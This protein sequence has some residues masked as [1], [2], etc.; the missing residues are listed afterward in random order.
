MV[1]QTQYI[2]R[3]SP[4]RG[5]VGTE[6]GSKSVMWGVGGGGGIIERQLRHN[7]VYIY[8]L[9]LLFN[10]VHTAIR[11][12][13]SH[14]H[15][16]NVCLW[17]V[18]CCLPRSTGRWIISLTPTTSSKLHLPQLVLKLFQLTDAVC[19]CVC[20]CVCVWYVALSV[21][22]LVVSFACSHCYSHFL[23]VVSQCGWCS[24]NL[25]SIQCAKQKLCFHVRG[26]HF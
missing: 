3:Q 19:V 26:L 24:L 16:H 8:F 11:I 7:N 15:E 17:T 18:F 25:N 14:M 6:R 21:W 5:L 23:L 10:L 12:A 9:K 22:L 20:V 1:L 2:H 13:S 4:I